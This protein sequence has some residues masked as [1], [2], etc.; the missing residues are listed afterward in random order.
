MSIAITRAW[1]RLS[2]VEPAKAGGFLTL[3]NDGPQADR[4]VGAESALADKIE[5]HGI[6]VVAA[7]TRMR[8]LDTGLGVPV[9]MP[10]ELKPR[11]YHLLFRD[12]KAP[13]QLGQKVPVT[14]LFETAGRRDVELVVEPAGPV[15]AQTLGIFD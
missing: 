14:L 9:G 6:R 4:L 8:L 11:G 15:G 12:L 13:F 5:I 2:D 3:N 1:A 10:I 7:A